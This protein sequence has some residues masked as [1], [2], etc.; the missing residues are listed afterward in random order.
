MPITAKKT[1]E[2][3]V[4]NITF[5]RTIIS[6]DTQELIFPIN[7]EMYEHKMTQAQWNYLVNGLRSLMESAPNITDVVIPAFNP[8]ME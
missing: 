6:W 1:I 8:N 4:K 2:A 5:G 7:G 3:S